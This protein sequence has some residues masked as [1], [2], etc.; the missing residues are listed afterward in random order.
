[1]RSWP[2]IQRSLERDVLPEWGARPVTEIRRRDVLE[3]VTRKAHAGLTAANRLQAHLSMLFAY[4]VEAD[5]LPANPAAGLRKRRE[6]ARTRVLNDE[7]V[8]TLWKTLDAETPI[9]LS[10]GTTPEK[11][12]TMPAETGE[13][14]RHL[15]KL[16]LI[17]G[18]RLGETSRMKWADVDL[19]AKLWTIP[20]T[21]TKNRMV[22]RVPL[23]EPAVELLKARQETAHPL[24]TY[25]FPSS[26][27][28]DAP[29]LVWSKRTASALAALTGIA[30]TAHDLRRTVATMM[31]ELGTD[32][33]TIGLV[34]NHRKPGVTTRHYDHS[35]REA[36]MRGSL[37]RWAQR[38]T[39]IVTET[40]AKVTPIRARA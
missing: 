24:A 5:W 23:S 16:L 7:D 39:Q 6:S 28:T 17:A 1:M 33:D 38:L 22:H 8:R 30:F 40:P 32:A 18:Q 14:L 13:T 27:K 15:F 9:A 3:L 11:R 2:Q 34:L 21:E 37:D 20:A 36:A 25:V 26:A 31:G 35:T 12:I 4:G 29:V 19:D 10:R